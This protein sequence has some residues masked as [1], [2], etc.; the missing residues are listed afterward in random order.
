MRPKSFTPAIRKRLWVGLLLVV[1]VMSLLSAMRYLRPAINAD[2]PTLGL[3]TS[4]PLQWS[5]GGIE[6]AITADA[7]PHPAYARLTESYNIV[8][9]D[10]LASLGRDRFST[11]LLAQP[12][13]LSPEELTQLDGWVRRGGRLL[14]L[15]DPALQ[16]GSLYPLGD[17]RRPLFTSLLSPLFKHWGLELVLPITEKLPLIETDIDG[18]NIRT[19]TLGAWQAAAGAANASCVIKEAD[20]VADCAIGKGRALLVAD[21]DFLDAAYW[22][23]NSFRSVIGDEF[24][25]MDWAQALL[26]DL[27]ADAEKGRDFPGK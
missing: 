3:M 18:Q 1:A 26:S 20:F 22:Q 12:R 19:Q 24:D 13:A 17:K 23:G 16:W 14:L 15:A 5:E 21:A 11:L 8:P 6:A 4:L 25:N 2:L 9:V 7:G 10:D 27:I